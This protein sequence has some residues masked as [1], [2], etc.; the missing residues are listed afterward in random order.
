MMNI[1]Q[2]QAIEAMVSDLLDVD[3]TF[4]ASKEDVAKIQKNFS[5][6]VSRYYDA[7][8][9]VVSTDPRVQESA[10][11]AQRLAVKAR[12]RAELKRC[13][14]C[15]VGLFLASGRRKYCSRTCTT[16]AVDLRRKDDPKRRDDVLR[17]MKRYYA[18]K[19]A[20]KQRGTHV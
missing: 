17:N 6:A 15:K 13:P 16:R 4:Y 3:P 7:L 10:T 5:Q 18:K 12:E 14:H 20:A 2:R 8:W 19:R 11:Y 9:N 1:A